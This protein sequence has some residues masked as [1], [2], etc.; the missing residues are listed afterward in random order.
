[1]RKS[2]KKTILAEKNHYAFGAHIVASSIDVIFLNLLKFTQIK[3]SFDRGVG[4][5]LLYSC[6]AKARNE[7]KN[8]VF[9]DLAYYSKW[10][11]VADAVIKA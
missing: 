7:R 10:P 2:T 1:M 11:K 3:W 5:P 8:K 6:N 9:K 4:R